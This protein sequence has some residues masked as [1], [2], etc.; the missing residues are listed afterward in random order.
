MKKSFSFFIPLS[1]ILVLL[2]MLIRPITT[3]EGAKTSLLIWFQSLL[4]SLLPFMILSGLLI[5]TGSA[6][7]CTFLFHP[8]IHRLFK[9]SKE[10]TFALITGFLC[11]FPMGAKTLAEFRLEQKISKEE[12]NFLLGFC[13]NFS[14]MFVL[15]I[16]C[17]QFSIPN[18]KILFIVFGS[19]FFYGLFFAFLFFK[20]SS[21]S[22]ILH[23]KQ[24][25]FFSFSLVDTAIMNGFAAITKLGGYL[26]LF[27]IFAKMVTALPAA[28]ILKSFLISLTEITNGITYTG[29]ISY[30]EKVKA[31][32]L[33]P[34]IAFGGLSGI[35]QTK[36]MITE[37]DLSIS[38]Y[39]KAKVICALIAILLT[40]ALC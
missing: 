21:F 39:L 34:G 2:F 4:P 15:S 29:S 30:P 35:A 26:I 38:S 3:L 13:N 16:L 9:T 36:S 25:L 18:W 14:P 37:T 19:P 31:L 8:L 12:G 33:L 11:G 22:S 1:L 5:S 27:G 6:I 7:F 17:P 10:G 40:L 20:K 23:K 28:T 32:L 24:P